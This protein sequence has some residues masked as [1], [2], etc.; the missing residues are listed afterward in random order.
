MKNTGT[1]FIVFFGFD[2]FLFFLR[3]AFVLSEIKKYK[4][5]NVIKYLMNP[6]QRPEHKSIIWLHANSIWCCY[7]TRRNIGQLKIC[8]ILYACV[9]NYKNL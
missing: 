7:L 8:F 6:P 3:M 9:I 5:Q 4:I 1:Y 2:L